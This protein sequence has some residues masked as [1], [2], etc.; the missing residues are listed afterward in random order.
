LVG[1][2]AE[3]G[4]ALA[5]VVVGDGADPDDDADSRGT[6]GIDA[7]AEAD[8]AADLVGDGVDHARRAL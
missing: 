8:S 2:K 5:A 4:S 1:T 6:A 3:V 7:G